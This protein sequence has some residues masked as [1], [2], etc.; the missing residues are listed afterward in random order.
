MKYEIRIQVADLAAYNN[1]K[2][3]GVWINAIDDSMS[4]SCIF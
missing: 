3:H 2:L 1:S 4:H